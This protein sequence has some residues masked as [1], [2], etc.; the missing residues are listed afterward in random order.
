MPEKGK[1]KPKMVTTWWGEKIEWCQLLSQK[2]KKN[3]G[4][5]QQLG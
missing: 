1:K 3:K 2:K 5:M 4:L